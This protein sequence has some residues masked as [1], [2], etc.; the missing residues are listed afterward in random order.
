M[1]AYLYLPRRPADRSSRTSRAEPGL[2]IDYTRAGRAIGVEI[3]TPRRIT[4][5]ALNRVMRQIGAPAL[6]RADLAPLKAA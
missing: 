6:T 2:L 5:A 3:T 1:A 4:L